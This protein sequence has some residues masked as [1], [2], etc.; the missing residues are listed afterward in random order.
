MLSTFKAYI[1]LARF[2]SNSLS[3][4]KIIFF[5]VETFD[6][7]FFFQWISSLYHRMVFLRTGEKCRTLLYLT[8]SF[9]HYHFGTLGTAET[10]FKVSFLI[11]GFRKDRT[12]EASQVKISVF[13]F[14][15]TQKALPWFF[16]TVNSR[17][18]LLDAQN[19]TAVY[20]FEVSL[21]NA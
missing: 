10:N 8:W 14:S 9:P 18:K 7:Q 17:D 1:Y 15:L 4:A 21:A 11:K 19:S 3:M 13:S 5:A 6:D 20:L 12:G 16:L 2:A